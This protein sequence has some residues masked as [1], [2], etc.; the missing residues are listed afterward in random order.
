MRTFC[1]IVISL[2]AFSC[3]DIIHYPNENSYRDSALF[4]TW[5]SKD[6]ILVQTKGD[7]LRRFFF[8]EPNGYYG[9][10]FGTA[11][12][13]FETLGFIWEVNKL[14]ESNKWIYNQ[15]H[16]YPIYEN[17]KK[18]TSDNSYFYN[19]TEFLDTLVLYNRDNIPY[20]TLY[21][22]MGYQLIYDGPDYVGVDSTG[23]E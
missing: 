4:G 6:S 5:Y 11:D 7:T 21:K 10:V 12:T 9:Q 20:D 16:E 15:I 17:W 1:F 19:S 8:Y 3:E 13:D 22:Y 2:L 18:K 14:S 23:I